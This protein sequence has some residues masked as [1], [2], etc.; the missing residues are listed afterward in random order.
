MSS[1]S[2]LILS[3]FPYI[4]LFYVQAEVFFFPQ[5]FD[6]ND[7]LL[8]SVGGVKRPA[9]GSKEEP[10]E[11]K[12]LPVVAKSFV[13]K[14][15]TESCLPSTHTAQTSPKLARASTQVSSHVKRHVISQL[16]LKLCVKMSFFYTPLLFKG[17]IFRI[18]HS[19][20]F[21]WVAKGILGEMG[22][23]SGSMF[24]HF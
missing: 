13:S 9:E 21:Q 2:S 3:F 12:N 23:L 1:S 22:Y 4:F 18:K 16:K 17:I 11:K 10:S 14:T 19:I 6:T 8:S 15:A 24:S 5:L 20:Y 7:V